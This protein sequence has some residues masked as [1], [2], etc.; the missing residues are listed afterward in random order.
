MK[1]LLIGIGVLVVLVV[2]AA[3]AAPFFI[4][5]DT[6]KNQIVAQTKSATGRDLR[7]DGPVKLS[8][9]PSI[10]VEVNKVVFA[11]APGASAKE[12][13][14]L[15]KL[16]VG[17]QVMP[18]LKGEVAVDRFVLVDPVINLE[19]DAK[20]K[21]N[22]QFG[23]AAPAAKPG[24]PAPAAKSGGGASGLSQ[25][26]LGDVR[27]ENGKLTYRDAKAGTTQTVDKIN[28]K[29][30]LPAIDKPF[31]ADG[32][33]DW[34]AKTVKLTAKI[35]N[36][37][38]LLIDNKAT[39]ATVKIGSEVV[40]L[41]FGGRVKTAPPLTVAGT[42]DLNVPSVRNLAAWT[43]NPVKMQ[44]NNLG[45][46]QIKGKIAVNGAKYAFTDAAINLDAIKTKGSMEFDGG[47]AK[48]YVK[49]GLDVEMLDLN[50]YLP[51]EKAAGQGKP[52]A[53]APASGSAPAKPDD[54]SDDPID[55][56]GLRAAD[57][58]LALNVGGIKVRKIEV[59]RSALK[60]ALK[61]GRMTADLTELNLYEGKGSG[62]VLLD[63]SGSIAGLQ[64][65]FKL[66]GLQIAPLLA[67]AADFGMMTGKGAMEIEM[68]SRGGTERQLVSAL[69]GKGGVKLNDGTIKGIDFVRMLCNPTQ[70]IQVLG[71]KLDQNAKTEFSEMNLSYTVVNGL[72]KNSD[73][74][75]LAPLFRAE[76]AGTV[77]LPKRTVN[78]RAVPKLVAS[79]TG[80]GGAAGKVGLGLPVIVDGP[81]SNVSVRPDFNPLEV[82]KGV[83]P[84]DALKDPKGAL[85][86][87]L[88]G[89]GGGSA[90]PSG[91]PQQQQQAPSG[92]G[93]GGALK[94]LMGR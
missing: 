22:W 72:L 35:A 57:A 14:T 33:V 36:P 56:A 86:G 40:N 1:K 51:P 55:L 54:W 60:V 12:M 24:Q 29:L 45:P 38:A 65:N 78:Y 9:F 67:A 47:G 77:D 39:D 32:S 15:A 73:L 75:V 59:G 76:G 61:G 63:G 71:G 27:L 21:P 46:L 43:G 37:Q 53:P 81:W 8:L 58:D 7:I 87:L 90:A 3:I 50:P 5:V 41:D 20:G 49:A 48:P 64:S 13:A 11:N 2:A 44:G 94:G 66:A 80:Q 70:A 17:L 89:A 31:E 74:A 26:R 42:V 16:Q 28:L 85:K 23:D 18:L 4:P 93:I 92:G 19:V 34:N 25:L 6:I 84:T 62:R 91:Q 88:P 83:V 68:T 82:L 69:N 52:A 30:K 10:A 79:C